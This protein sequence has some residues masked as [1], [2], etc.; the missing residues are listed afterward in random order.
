[1][2][3]FSVGDFGARGDGSTDDSDAFVKAL[4]AARVAGGTLHIP[5]GRY[6]I[7][8]PLDL[9]PIDARKPRRIELRGGPEKPELQF[10][11]R[12]AAFAANAAR[13]LYLSNLR[14]G[15]TASRM[16][17]ISR[18][19]HVVIRDCVISGA[20]ETAAPGGPFGIQLA[21]VSDALLENNDLTSNGA[22][23]RAGVDIIVDDAGGSKISI[24]NNRCRSRDVVVGIQLTNA[25]WSNITR[26]S[27][28][29]VSGNGRNNGYGILVSSTSRP[30][31]F[32]DVVANEVRD[33]D[34]SGIYLRG[35]LNCVVSGN[36]IEG[37]AQGQD[38]ARLNVA[39]IA[40]T[41]GPNRIVHNTVLKCRRAG[42]SFSGRRT[43]VASNLIANIGGTGI[44]VRGP[45]D[46]S[47]IVD[48]I[49]ARTRSGIRNWPGVNPRSIW[50]VGNTIEDLRSPEH[51]ISFD[52]LARSIVLGNFLYT[53]LKA[54][55]LVSQGKGNTV[56][57]ND[58]RH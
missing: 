57:S 31:R 35:A 6:L 38:D 12:D 17:A 55:V 29:G 26:N 34:G 23:T 56:R 10:H 37:A 7:H 25:V 58:V 33:T 1:M 3:S 50:I 14:I 30:C 45:C 43:V 52:T 2:G 47:R 19:Q 51:P 18:S 22:P 28:S 16:V 40:V 9:S 41:S 4:R 5:G 32:V 27:V 42:I 8:K 36:T 44:L 21:S 54:G 15:G 48:N 11:V 46:N 24:R 13:G 39:G 20:V 53:E 49:V